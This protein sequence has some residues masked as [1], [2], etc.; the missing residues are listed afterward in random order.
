MF[1]EQ[2]VSV[3]LKL[4][5]HVTQELCVNAK[6]EAH[7]IAKAIV[8]VVRLGVS[9]KIDVVVIML[10]TKFVQE[11]QLLIVKLDKVYYVEREQHILVL[12]D[13]FN[14]YVIVKVDVVVMQKNL[15]VPYKDQ[16]LSS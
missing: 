4:V 6:I 3:I 8:V 10:A 12:E 5:V 13:N 2:L 9:A 14:H 16:S 7:V 11:E 15:S 1:Q